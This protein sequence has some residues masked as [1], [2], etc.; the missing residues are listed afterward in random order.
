MA[1]IGKCPCYIGS[2]L[3]IELEFFADNGKNH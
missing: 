3:L 1:S 2:E